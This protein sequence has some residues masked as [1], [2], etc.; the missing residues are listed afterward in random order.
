MM[1]YELNRL[2]VEATINGTH[3]VI[4]GTITVDQLRDLLVLV[5][6]VGICVK[7]GEFEHGVQ[8]SH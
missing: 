1:L 2:L 5:E 4:D 6:Q 7:K 3:S 8:G